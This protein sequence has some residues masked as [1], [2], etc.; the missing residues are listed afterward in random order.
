MTGKNKQIICQEALRKLLEFSYRSDSPQMLRN[1]NMVFGLYFNDSS[2]GLSEFKYR[3]L[4]QAINQVVRN[5]DRNWM[6]RYWEFADQ[7]YRSNIEYENKRN[8]DNKFF[9]FHVAVGGLLALN[10]K[11]EWIEHIS[12]FTNILPPKYS[13]IP[14]TFSEIFNWLKYFSKMAE[15]TIDLD[16]RYHLYSQYEGVRAG[17]N[18]YKGI[19]KYMALMMCRLPE[20][21]F[22]VRYVNPKELPYI[23]GSTKDESKDCESVN[24]VNIQICKTLEQSL[25]ELE[26]LGFSVGQVAFDLLTDYIEA[27]ENQI[28]SVKQID[29]DKINKMKSTLLSEF[30]RLQT[31]LITEK[32][33][34]LKNYEKHSWF[35]KSINKL[36]EFDILEGKTCYNINRESFMIRNIINEAILEYS[37]VLRNC[38]T[39]YTYVVRFIDIV[40]AL[41]KLHIPDGYVVLIGSIGTHLLP[42]DFE[43]N[44]NIHFIYSN[45]SEILVLRKDMLPFVCFEKYVCIEDK[46][47]EVKKCNKENI[48]ELIDP[49]RSEFLFSNIWN[50]EMNCK[51]KEIAETKKSFLLKVG[52]QFSICTPPKDKLTCIRIKATDSITQ[53]TFDLDKIERMDK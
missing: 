21:D 38:N 6:Y 17:A 4:W 25:K 1:D 41:T 8:K 16:I 26:S 35:A 22:N 36:E 53:S 37:E 40:K 33:S 18:L 23:Y 48:Y 10:E 19:V 44:P 42:A 27:C 46:C 43:N 3:C 12:W 31:V 14:S 5:E 2:H 52:C 49:D 15:S 39:Q 28:K 20:I 24:C 34:T 7:Y 47:L 30:N 9:E 32:D 51:Q 29:D 50:L 13:L 11:Y 45:Q